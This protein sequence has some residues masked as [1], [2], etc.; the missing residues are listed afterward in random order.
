MNDLTDILASMPKRAERKPDEYL[1]N[2][3]VHI[4][5]LFSIFSSSENQILFGRRGTGKTHLLKYLLNAQ[6]I[7]GSIGIEVDMRTMGSTGGLYSDY[8]IETSERATRLLSDVLCEIREQLLDT[9]QLSDECD[10]SALAPLLDQFVEEATNVSIEGVVETQTSSIHSAT[11]SGVNEISGALSSTPSLGIKRNSSSSKNESQ[12]ENLKTTGKAKIRMHFGSLS[13][14]LK[15]I[16]SKLPN[17]SLLIVIDEWSEVPIELQPY[18]A[19]MFRRIVFPIPTVTVKIAAISHRSKFQFYSASNQKIGLEISADASASIN[20]DQFMVFDNDNDKAVKFFEG[21]IH[22]HAKAADRKNIVPENSEDFTAQVFKNRS[23]LEEFARASEGVPRD[24]IHII[25][26]AIL[27]NSGQKLGV[28][29]IRNAARYWYTNSKSKDFNSK[30]EAVRLLDWII[31]SVIGTKKTRGF[32]VQAELKDDLLDFLFDSRVIH[33][34]KQG[35]AV[36]TVQ[37][38]KFNLYS[39]DY[40]CYAH[41]INTKDEPKGLLKSE[42]EYILVPKIDS[43]YNRTSIL[44]FDNYYN[45]GQL[46]FVEHSDDIEFTKHYV[47]KDDEHLDFDDQVF[48][49]VPKY[50]EAIRVKETYYIPLIL[51]A[52]V[53][54]KRLGI[55]SSTGSE[56]TK[57]INTY[58]ISN[59]QKSK[60][61]NNVSRALREPPLNREKW[62]IT[63]MSG[64]TPRFSLSTDWKSYWKRYL[65]TNPPDV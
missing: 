61:P 54:Q 24:A 9:C 32:L 23:A 58:I 39:L 26:H 29:S 48:E 18:L 45:N 34:V 50:L 11:S 13:K 53:I 63:E 10:L 60:A 47:S 64:K 20:L 41:L 44:D 52:L 31:N 56:I 1:V 38:K 28:K 40:G 49:T 43:M 12:G 62:L 8:Q 55:E 21:L 59:D 2:S 19:D 42:S 14:I 27:H 5:S 35:V 36:K 7:N 17:K 46:P 6:R 57:V 4:G 22:K 37:G 15:K 25:S 65:S 33:V 16:V 3:F 51:V 30:A